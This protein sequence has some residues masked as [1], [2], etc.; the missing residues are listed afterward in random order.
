MNTVGVTIGHVILKFLKGNGYSRL[1]R[2]VD[3]GILFR[4]ERQRL[5]HH[6][7]LWPVGMSGSRLNGKEFSSDYSA[8][9]LLR[10]HN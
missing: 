7:C 1:R 6:I 8:G 4:V 3:V 2:N 9:A 5:Q 10:Y